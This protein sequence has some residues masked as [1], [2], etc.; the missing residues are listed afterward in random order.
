M[1]WGRVAAVASIGL[2]SF[3]IAILLF[4]LPNLYMKISNIQFSV[5][6]EMNSF[7]SA[8][9]GIGMQS[10]HIAAY[11]A[12]GISSFTVFFLI[13]SVPQLISKI[14]KIHLEVDAAGDSFKGQ[15]YKIGAI[16]KKHFPVQIVRERRYVAAG[17]C[18][19]NEFNNCPAGA[20]GQPG[21]PGSDACI[22]LVE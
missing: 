13:M 17:Q 11:A 19:C 12:I 14:N 2:S 4:T 18:Q 6:E 21:L 1:S 3:S 7:K 8:E 9:H 22:L 16:Q 20:P 15:E 10:G 5:E